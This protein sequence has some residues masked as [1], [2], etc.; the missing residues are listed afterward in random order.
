MI[1]NS[2]LRKWDRL[3]KKQ[4]DSQFVNEIIKGLNCSPFESSAI[5]E[6]VHKVYSTYFETSGKIKPGQ[7][8]FQVA[9]INMAVNEQIENGAQTTV[10]LTVDA[11]AEDL[12]IRKAEGVIGLRRY[13][14]QRVC[15]EAFQQDG[16]FTLEDLAIRLFN[17]GERTISRDLKYFKEHNISLPLRSFIKDMGRSISH[18]SL[19]IKHWLKG[20]E[21]S[22]IS[23]ATYHTIPSVK[24]YVNKFKRV[25][26]LA[27]EGFDIHT[28]GFLVKISSSLVEEYYKIYRNNDIVPSRKDEIKFFLKTTK[29]KI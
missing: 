20:K 19:I 28:I 12:K 17:C 7:I 26:A 10:V 21:Y 5:L 29:N 24:N 11:G 23:R 27:E 18:R 13:R 2:S 4:L 1:N 22:D 9:S 16:L 8:L 3:A 25:V 15:E 6:T 14:I